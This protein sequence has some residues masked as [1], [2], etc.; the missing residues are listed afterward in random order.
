MDRYSYVRHQLHVHEAATDIGMFAADDNKRRS[1]IYMYNHTS[2]C[3]LKLVIVCSTCT[4]LCLPMSRFCP[5]ITSKEE[6]NSNVRVH[7]QHVAEFS[8]P[9]TRQI[10]ACRANL[11]RRSAISVREFRRKS[12]VWMT[13]FSNV[14]LTSKSVCFR[15]AFS[16]IQ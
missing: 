12:P 9:C 3:R 10:C 11:V 4:G 7:V 6:L 14:E 16:S 8:H 13:Y 15:L 5:K 2:V 1:E